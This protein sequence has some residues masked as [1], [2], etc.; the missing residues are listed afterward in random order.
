MSESYEESL[1]EQEIEFSS[2][3][4]VSDAELSKTIKNILIKILQ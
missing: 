2:E 1:E 4:K 3:K